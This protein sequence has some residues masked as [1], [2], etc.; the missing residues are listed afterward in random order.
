MCLGMTE[1][2]RESPC[3]GILFIWTAF[4]LYSAVTSLPGV[5]VKD[6]MHAFA[7]VFTCIHAFLHYA[8][9]VIGRRVCAR[10]YVHKRCSVTY[11]CVL[12]V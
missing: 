7:F 1:R 6:K 3:V 11:V 2:E 5:P 4:S 8:E 10:A 9:C 12:F